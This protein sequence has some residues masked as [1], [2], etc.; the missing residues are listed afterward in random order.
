MNKKILIAV[1]FLILVIS[2]LL[3]APNSGI[4]KFYLDDKHYNTNAQLIDISKSDLESVIEKKQSFVVFTYLP[5]CT[6]KI[7]CDII[8]KQFLTNHKM[9]FYSIPYD[10]F[11][12]IELF[13]NIKYAPSVVIVKKGKVIAYLDANKDEDLNKYQDVQEFDKWIT[14]YIKIK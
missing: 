7:P 5:Y 9:S 4:N 14:N 10:E 6:L 11:T 12:N 8:F 2:V 1:I 13:K 3:L